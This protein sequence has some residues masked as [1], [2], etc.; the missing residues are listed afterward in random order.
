MRQISKTILLSAAL[1]VATTAV[2]AQDAETAYFTDGY[3]YGFEMNPA[4]G[5][6][7][8]FISI[9]VLGNL[10]VEMQSNFR[11]DNFVF[12]K[13]GKTVLF[14]NPQVTNEEFLGGIN[15]DNKMSVDLKAQL[16][17]VGFK[18]LGGYNTISLSTRANVGANV[19]G[20]IF[21]LA[22]EG[23]S[24]DTYSITNMNVHADAYAEFALGHQHQIGDKLS[25][26]V[27]LKYLI[28][29]ANIDAHFNKA[30]LRLGEDSW[31]ITTNAEVEASAKGLKYETETTMRGPEGQQTPHTYVNGVNTDDM[32]AP[33]G[34]GF[35]IDLGAEYEIIDGLKVSAAVLD[36][37][38]IKYNN[39]MVAATQGDHHFS[40]AD[41]EFNANDD[42]SNSFE[43]E[44][45]NMM[46]DLAKL[47][48]LK[49]MGD[50][51]SV[52]RNL[53]TTINAGVEYKMPFYK[54]LSVGALYTKKMGDYGWNKVRFSA[55]LAPTKWF[56]LT[57]SVATGTYGTSIGGALN[58]HPTGFN[59]F[60]AM[61]HM[62][63][64]VTKQNIP[65]SGNASISMG[66]N[67]PF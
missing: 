39:N 56:A 38:Y 47:Y 20:D 14:T 2:N 51:G 53:N 43:N 29:F 37:G 63:T 5:N 21:R 59:L 52:K 35:A 4:K 17:A 41:Y 45:D 10:N 25:V 42:A 55:N 54:G 32:S 57:G 60:L 30:E 11:V 15:D 19:P 34:S 40:T 8:N 22:K 67:I 13:G 18:G 44:A 7:Q 64:S 62:V 23:L 6:S 28:G 3:L 36:L 24:N 1:A 46:E 58:L 33:N 27:N 65:L 9:P 26:G 48:E 49:D 31:D 16:F 50:K 61:D 12:D 66:V